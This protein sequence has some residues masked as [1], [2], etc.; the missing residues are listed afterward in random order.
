VASCDARR[1]A[2]VRIAPPPRN[3]VNFAT[4]DSPSLQFLPRQ[5]EAQIWR[6]DED[7]IVIPGDHLNTY[8][9]P[10]EAPRFARYE[11]LDLTIGKYSTPAGAGFA[12]VEIFRFPDFVKAFGAYS[13][14]KSGNVRF[15]DIPN[16][17]FAKAHSVHV[18]RG[19]F[20]VRI[21]GAGEGDAVLRLARFVSDRMPPAPNKPAVFAFLP[22][23]HRVT[24]S[25]RYSADSAFG[26]SFLAN[27]FQATFNVDNDV[28]EG[29]VIPAANKQTA[30][31]ILDQYKGLYLHNGKLL[32]PIPNL[33]EDNFTA[34]DRFLGR[35]VAFRIDR[36]IVAFNGF[37]ERQHLLDL[38]TAADQRILG[39]IRKQLV[40]ADQNDNAN[41]RNSATV[42]AWMKRR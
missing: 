20:Y 30:E 24:G 38:A 33:G 2:Q 17:S 37:H 42:P 11:T 36:F 12:T 5:Q 26:Q 16:E 28:I 41:D 14:Q 7:P 10:V 34:E 35:V 13:Q 8:L 23:G 21:T 9:G 6:L 27:S 25:E 39:T 40:N 29:I 22:D 3:E 4:I 1:P 19:P 32:D 31:N 15:L 18:W